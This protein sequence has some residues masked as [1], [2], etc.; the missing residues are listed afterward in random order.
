[1]STTD[2]STDTCYRHPDRQSF[3]LCQRCGRTICP[4]C[5]I[6][7]PVGFQCPEC[8]AES[9]ASAPRTRPAVVSRMRGLSASGAPVVTYSLIGVT[10][11]VYLAQLLTGGLVT[12]LLFY[13]PVLTVEEPWRMLTAALV[14]SQTS[15]LHVLF[16]MFTLWVFGRILEPMIGRWRFLA[17]YVISAFGGSV[18]VLLISPDTSVVGASGAIFGLMGATVVILRGLG[19]NSTQLLALIAINL[20]IGF[21]PGFRISWEGHL[22]GLVAGALVGLVYSRTR[23]LRQR[24]QQILLTAAVAVGLILLTVIGVLTRL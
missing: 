12:S 23:A 4:E 22:G 20:A 11:L 16:N 10:V 6:P 15:F 13:A 17:L 9:R 14:H 3:I 2:R 24:N 5:Q 18:A 21:L 7:A 1:M 19:G 8:V